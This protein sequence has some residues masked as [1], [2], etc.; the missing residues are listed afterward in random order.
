MKP[1]GSKS[2]LQPRERAR[3][4]E[5][6]R[7]V[8]R[9]GGNQREER[10]ALYNYH[11]LMIQ[12]SLCASLRQE[13]KVFFFLL[14]LLIIHRSVKRAIA[15]KTKKT[16]SVCFHLGV[17]FSCVNGS[18]RWRKDLVL[19]RPSSYSFIYSPF[20]L[21]SDG[22]HSSAVGCRCCK[23]HVCQSDRHDSWI[24]DF[25]CSCQHSVPQCPG[26]PG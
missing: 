6:V 20:F 10:K 4:R 15:E 18:S 2:E 1:C 13:M 19:Q 7:A 26:S 11:A 9:A 17:W 21:S 16:R 25:V 8:V 23:Q 12:C 5:K 3:E 14:M 22:E 24:M